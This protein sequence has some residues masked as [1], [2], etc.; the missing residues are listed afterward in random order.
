MDRDIYT[1]RSESLPLFDM[2]DR[3]R[4]T[5]GNAQALSWT[6]SSPAFQ[7]SVKRPRPVWG[8]GFSSLFRD[9]LL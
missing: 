1:Y 2:F 4:E 5:M 8:R 3:E 9:F 7:K 6:Q